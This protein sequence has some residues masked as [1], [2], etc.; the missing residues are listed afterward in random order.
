MISNMVFPEIYFLTNLDENGVPSGA[1]PDMGTI[2]LLGTPVHLSKA[3]LEKRFA[4][5][6]LGEHTDEILKE[7]GYD[8]MYIKELHT[9]RIL[10]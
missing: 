4:P 9:L 6:K 7:I 5:P 10:G 1:H 3:P 2:K 8:E